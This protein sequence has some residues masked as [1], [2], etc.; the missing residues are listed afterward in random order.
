M[1]DCKGNRV[2]VYVMK[3]KTVFSAQDLFDDETHQ[4]GGGLRPEIKERIRK[5]RKITKSTLAIQAAKPA[6]TQNPRIPAMIAITK[7]KRVHDNICASFV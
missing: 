7:N 1:K 5:I 3:E 4:T 2:G 6:T